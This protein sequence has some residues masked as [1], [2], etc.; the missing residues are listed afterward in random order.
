[1]HLLL[2]MEGEDRLKSVEEIDDVICAELPTIDEEWLSRTPEQLE[3]LT[4]EENDQLRL[5]NIVTKQMV[6]KPC[7]ELNPNESCMIKGK[8][9]WGFPKR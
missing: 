9:R 3:Q 2:V 5:W 4:K 1:M 6:H 8:C 7:G